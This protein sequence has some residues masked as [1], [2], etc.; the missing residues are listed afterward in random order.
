MPQYRHIF[1]GSFRV[2][3]LFVKTLALYCGTYLL[4]YYWPLFLSS[5]LAP[6]SL[7]QA[8]AFAAFGLAPLGFLVLGATHG[9]RVA[10]VHLTLLIVCAAMAYAS[11]P[12]DASARVEDRILV[13]TIFL[14]LAFLVGAGF[15]FQRQLAR[16]RSDV[17]LG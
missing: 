13:W 1:R 15:G 2:A 4:C 3:Y 7:L 14:G 12:G 11:T 6:P 16:H 17:P 9:R 10:I 8:E 5:M